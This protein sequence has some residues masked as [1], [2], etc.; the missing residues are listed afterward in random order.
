MRLRLLLHAIF[1]MYLM[2]LFGPSG[3]GL[4]ASAQIV[5]YSDRDGDI[6]RNKI[7]LMNE[8]GSNLHRVG[9]LPGN[10]ASPKL[11]PNN[12]KIVFEYSESYGSGSQ[13]YIMSTD[14]SHAQILTTE[15]NGNHSPQVMPE[16]RI[17][18]KQNTQEARTLYIM[19]Q[20][21]SGKTLF[22]IKATGTA[23]ADLQFLTIGPGGMIAF[24]NYVFE[25]Y[26]TEHIYTMK[27]DGSQ[28]QRLTNSI[29]SS[30]FIALSPDGKK[31]V[32]AN[33][34]AGGMM[35][36][37]HH[38]NDGLYIMNS[39][40]TNTRRIVQVDFSQDLGPSG[41]N[42]GTIGSGRKTVGL[43]APPSFSPDGTKLTYAVNIDGKYHV[44]IVNSD[45][46][47]LKQLT[48]SSRNDWAPSFSR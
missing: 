31:M 29:E 48:S 16:G 22:P 28:L 19:N 35:L 36:P 13:I 12:Q 27:I 18:Y 15:P 11:T 14:G 7:Y 5:F 1:V 10:H 37:A 20:D 39:D 30:R 32:Y 43:L 9:T 46:T 25:T 26:T 3:T 44:Y 6:L 17:V 24:T 45:G 8:D 41:N 40:G 23:A 33:V 21:G 42:I 38:E 47:G 34:G 2:L 4:A